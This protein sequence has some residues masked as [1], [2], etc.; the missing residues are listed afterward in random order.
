M[1]MHTRGGTNGHQWWL[2]LWWYCEAIIAA[3]VAFCLQVQHVT[4][5]RTV[6]L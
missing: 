2:N 1:I 3:P 4:F 6:C 5:P